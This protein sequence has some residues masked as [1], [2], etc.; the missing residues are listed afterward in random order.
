MGG[1]WA[2]EGGAPTVQA[3]TVRMLDTTRHRVVLA[4]LDLP[5]IEESGVLYVLAVRGILGEVV[6]VLVEGVAF[7]TGGRMHL[8]WS[9]QVGQG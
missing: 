4:H 2:G 8:P 1:S 9:A 6:D 5:R 3:P 7:R